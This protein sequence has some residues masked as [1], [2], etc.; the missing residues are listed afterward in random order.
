V[1]PRLADPVPGP[2]PAPELAR[3]D[4]LSAA[5]AAGESAS[6][7]PA[8]TDE[9]LGVL[10][11]VLERDGQQD[12]ASQVGRQGLGDADHLAFLNSIW[13]SETAPARHQ[14]YRDLYLAALPPGHRQEPGH[15]AKW[16]WRTLRAAE[17]AGL[18]LAEALAAAIG[19]RDLTGARD[20]PSVIDA[21]LRRR[22]GTLA[23]RAAGRWSAQPT[24]ITDPERRAYT[25]QIA[26]LMD[27]RKTRI[28][29]H[30]ATSALPWAVTALGPVPGPGPDRLEWQRRASSIG[31]YRELSGYGH[32]TDPIGPEPVTGTP[33]LRAAWHEALTALGTV[34]G[35]D[36]RGMPDGRLLHLR[37]TLPHRD[38]L[39]AA[40][41]WRRAPAGPHRSMGSPAG[42]P[43][44]HIH[45][46]VIPGLTAAAS[47]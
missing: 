30:A 11:E 41:D 12:S 28:G 8:A 24:G 38:R 9:A 13:T 23:P 14:R 1:S 39:G 7:S 3:H 32:P 43:H 31:A 18:D 44:P 15:Q 17:L 19:E 34:D 46:I 47:E 16:L 22:A 42:L 27:E 37:D 4:R 40:V 36:V 26:T 35:P 45:N 33:D 20:I 5:Q 21:R 25:A 29:Q 6:P 2:R 10:A